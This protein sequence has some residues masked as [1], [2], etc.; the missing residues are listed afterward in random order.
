MILKPGPQRTM[1]GVPPTA[2]IGLRPPLLSPGRR[3]QATPVWFSMIRSG[4]SVAPVPVI[5]GMYGILLTAVNGMKLLA[6]LLGLS[7]Q[8]TARLSSITRCGLSEGPPSSVLASPTSR[9]CGIPLM[10]LIGTRPETCPLIDLAILRWRMTAG[11]GLSE[12]MILLVATRAPYS[13]APHL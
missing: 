9:M 11:C 13:I 10:A 3:A 12:D 1:F 4:S 7:A 5:S 8:I 6:L 2:P